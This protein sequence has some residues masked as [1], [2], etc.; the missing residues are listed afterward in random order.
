MAE[1]GGTRSGTFH[2]EMDRCRESQRGTTACSIVCPNNVTGR[3][4][5]R[6]AQSE[7]VRAGSLA[8]IVD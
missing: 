8:I 4:K 1:D 3:T 7:R 2:G 6:I 5:N